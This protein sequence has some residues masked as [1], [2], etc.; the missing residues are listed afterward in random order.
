MS[1]PCAPRSEAQ[2][3]ASP[4][5]SWS[6]ASC[7]RSS[8][9]PGGVWLARMLVKGL[10]AVYPTGLPR[11]GE[12]ALDGRV[13]AVALGATLLTGLLAG[14]PLSRQVGRLDVVR[15]L[16]QGERGLGSRRR[17][18]LLDGLIVGQVATSVALLFAAGIL[19]QRSWTWLRSSRGSTCATSSPSAPRSRRRDTPHP[20]DSR[21]FY[22][23]L[24]DS[25][26]AVP[27]VTAV[28]WAMFAPLGGGGWGDNFARVGSADAAPNLPSMQVKMVSPGVCPDSAHS[29]LAGRPS[30][31][32]TA[33]ALLMSPS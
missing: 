9:A 30:D 6:R 20:N 14:L 33:L 12:I 5:S 22:D 18:R 10:V 2:Q 28:G 23:A 25:L 32:R 26:R 15:D 11:A 17:R 1:S 19:L 13:L 31:R 29:L 4:A 7:S 24:F 3:A 27:G 16:R 8:A 21:A